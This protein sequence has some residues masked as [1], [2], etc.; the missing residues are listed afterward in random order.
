MVVVLG[1]LIFVHELGH[2]LAAKSVDIEVPRFSIG[3]GP[4][5]FGF[6][7]GETE[8]VIS[9]LPLGGYVKMA[10]M[11]DEAVSAPL[12][13][14]MTTDRTPSSRDF[15]AKPLWART[16]VILAGVTMN[17]LFAVVAFTA[18]TLQQ[19]VVEPRVAE[20]VS[21]SPA[22]ESGLLAGD[23][24]V[25]IDGRRVRDPTQVTMAIEQRPGEEITVTVEREGVRLE[26]RATP[27]PVKRYSEL[28]KDTVTIGRIGVML[29]GPGSRREV[30]VVR[31]A[32]EGLSQT[33]YWTVT[34][35]RFVKDLVTGR[36]S[37][38]EVG[39]PVMI[40]QLSGRAARA[41]IWSLLFFTAIISVNLAV[42]NLLPIPVL[43]GGH[44]VFLAVEAVRGRALS[45]EQRIRWTTAGMVLVVGLMVWAIGN[46]LLRLFGI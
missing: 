2:F 31:A 44:L 1:V 11:A 3:L 19:G 21:E 4:K 9:W 40:G 6:R 41:G 29:G 8:Y 35:T 42:L 30:G 43:D 12:E 32:G 17:W 24:M 33:G 7:R 16:F 28:A 45:M 26:L 27:E 13:G 46:D 10:G 37:L 20:V 34:V 5:L 14:G 25:A 22:E 15:E 38:R 36:A 18:L 39:G 23:L